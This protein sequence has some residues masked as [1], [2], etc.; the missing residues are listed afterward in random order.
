[1]D[2]LD[3]TLMKDFPA[4]SWD[5]NTIDSVWGVLNGKLQAM[6]GPRPTTP[7]GWRCHV[8]RAWAS[9]DQATINKLVDD[10]PR[11]VARIVKQEGSWLFE[12]GKK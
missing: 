9:I 12:K 5:L 1:M 6:P 10:V 2:Q 7:Y 3:L 4:Q 11:G 8:M